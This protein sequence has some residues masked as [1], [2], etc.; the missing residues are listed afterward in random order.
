MTIL[1]DE[2]TGSPAV[3]KIVR[4]MLEE[5]GE[6]PD[7]DGLHGT[8]DRVARSL[9]FLTSGYAVDPREVVGDALFEAEYDEMVV[10][11]DVEMYSMCEHHML[12]FFG[13]CH[14]AYLPTKKIV[15]LSKLAR[16]VEVFS[17]R[18]QVQERLTTQI[19]NAINDIVEPKGVG[20]V[21]EAHHL[22]MMMRGIQKQNSLAVTSCM[23]G[24]FRTDARTRTEFLSLIAK[25]DSP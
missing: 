7:R 17:R 18:L 23:L 9:G 6:D 3:A 21:I 19:A 24:S 20:V 15:G 14:I 10:V 25:H 4:S 16:L 11:R 13:R 22:C 1:N 5:L 8:P 12:P 2:Q